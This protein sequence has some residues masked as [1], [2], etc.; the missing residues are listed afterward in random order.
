[1]HNNSNHSLPIG[2]ANVLVN[3]LEES[4]SWIDMK[5]VLSLIVFSLW[6]SLR[7]GDLAAS[8]GGLT[9]LPAGAEGLML[10]SIR[11]GSCD[12]HSGLMNVSG[13]YVDLSNMPFGTVG[14]D[15]LNY[16]D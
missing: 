8:A 1:M 6:G 12:S 10:L 4:R 2:S 11:F 16:F 9:L 5:A 14:I 7:G 15:N 13:T 3:S